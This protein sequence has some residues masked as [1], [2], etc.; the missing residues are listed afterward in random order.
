M[1]KQTA[2]QGR[3]L[4]QRGGREQLEEVN[5]LTKTG[6]PKTDDVKDLNN[7]SFEIKR[8]FSLESETNKQNLIQ[9]M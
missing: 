6:K 1:H 7:K 9:I 5:C 2:L 3:S 4:Q 8:H